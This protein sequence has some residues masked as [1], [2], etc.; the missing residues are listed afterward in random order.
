MMTMTYHESYG[1]LPTR[2]LNLYKNNNASP[3]DH[4]QVLAAFD[5]AWNDSDIP[6]PL[7][8][9]FVEAHCQYGQLRL[10]RYM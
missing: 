6:W 2:L 3:A 1:S 8:V 5:C 9:D 7:V 4:D 10:P